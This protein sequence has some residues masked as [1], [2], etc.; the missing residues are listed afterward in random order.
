MK[1]IPGTK[2]ETGETWGG[3]SPED[4]CNM[5]STFI[6]INELLFKTNMDAHISLIVS[7]IALVVAVLALFV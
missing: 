2:L 5:L 1:Q 4:S 3:D 7:I 6:K